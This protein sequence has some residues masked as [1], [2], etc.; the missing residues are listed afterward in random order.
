LVSQPEVAESL[1]IC[2]EAHYLQG[3]LVDFIFAETI[4][5]KGISAIMVFAFRQHDAGDRVEP[6][7]FP[8]G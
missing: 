4:P 1:G 3:K 8:A 7:K 2:H 5:E 6:L